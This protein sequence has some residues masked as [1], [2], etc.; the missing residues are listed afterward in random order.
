M[1]T[2]VVRRL[3]LSGVTTLVGA[4]ICTNGEIFCRV[5]AYGGMYLLTLCRSNN[6]RTRQRRRKLLLDEM[7]SNERV[8]IVTIG[9]RRSTTLTIRVMQSMRIYTM[10]SSILNGFGKKSHRLSIS[11]FSISSQSLSLNGWKSMRW[12][13]IEIL[14]HWTRSNGLITLVSESVCR[15][16]DLYSALSSSHAQLLRCKKQ[17]HVSRIESVVHLALR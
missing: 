14:H 7:I 10:V 15:T 3:V 4:T 1:T 2:G 13:N 17:G 16:Y 6:F 11:V 9:L 5:R 12:T 8:T